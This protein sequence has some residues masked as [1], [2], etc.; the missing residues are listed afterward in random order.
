MIE[1]LVCFATTSARSNLALID[2]AQDYLERHGARCRRTANA[3][4]SKAN[5]FASLGPDSPGGVVLSGHSDVVP[6]DGQPWGSDPF[7][8]AERDGRL[9]GRGTADMKSRSE[10]PTSE[11]QSLMRISY[12][13]F[14]VK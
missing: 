4:G 10:E 2:F 3:E 12:A 1:R 8:V 9:Y 13:V 7:R 5:L 11:L 14:Y 6:V